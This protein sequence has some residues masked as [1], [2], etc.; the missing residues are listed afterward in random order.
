MINLAI[1]I[2]GIFLGLMRLKMV[3]F[4]IGVMK[5]EVIGKFVC[6][7]CSRVFEINGIGEVNYCPFCGSYEVYVKDDRD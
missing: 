1:L 5:M 2:V 4:G 7:A 3:L 6:N